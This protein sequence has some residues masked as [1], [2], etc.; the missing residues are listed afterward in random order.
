MEKRNGRMGKINCH[1]LGEE[2][3]LKEDE[4]LGKANLKMEP[5]SNLEGRAATWIPFRD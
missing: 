5:T 4:R 1:M 3:R 2:K